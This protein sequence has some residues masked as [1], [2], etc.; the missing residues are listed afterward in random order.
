MIRPKNETEDLIISKTKKCET[1]K[2]QTH[3]K[4]E[5]TMEFMITQPIETFH[6][7]PS[8]ILGLDSNRMIGVTSLKDYNFIFFFNNGR[9]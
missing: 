5:E 4:P 7:K 1:L 6:F 8:I 2:K 9:K 3:R